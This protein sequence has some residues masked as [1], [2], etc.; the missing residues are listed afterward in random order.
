MSRLAAA[1]LPFAALVTM[2][3]AVTGA[4]SPTRAQDDAAGTDLTLTGQTFAVVPGQPWRVELDPRRS[5]RRG[6][7]DAPTST[8]TTTVAPVPGDTTPP[9]PAETAPADTVDAALRFTAGRP[10]ATRHDLAEV[11]DGAPGSSLTRSSSRSLRR[12]PVR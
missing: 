9:P 2:T 11:L 7:G 8:T 6:R 12:P 10:V 5:A 4:P 1:G 3:L